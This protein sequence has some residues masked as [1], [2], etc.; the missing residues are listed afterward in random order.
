MCG[1]CT[2]CWFCLLSDMICDLCFEDEPGKQVRS[3]IAIKN[4]CKSHVAFKVRCIWLLLFYSCVIGFRKWYL[5]SSF[6]MLH[7]R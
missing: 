5:T 4:T 1:V 2:G 7:I 3:A 6:V